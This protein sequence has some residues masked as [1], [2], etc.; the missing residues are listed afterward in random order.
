MVGPLELAYRPSR[1]GNPGHLPAA[2]PRKFGFKD[3]RRSRLISGASGSAMFMPRPY[4]KARPGST[5]GYDIIDHQ[6]STRSSAPRRISP[7]WCRH[8]GV[9]ASARFSI[10]YPNHMGVGGSDNP[11][12]L[13]VL[14]W[15]PDFEHAGWF[16][17]DWEPEGTTG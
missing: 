6:R 10:S 1:S 11:L 12:W 15:G 17:I 3:A 13:D 2:V 9:K 5:H 14:E 16:D 7:P 4:L 8:S